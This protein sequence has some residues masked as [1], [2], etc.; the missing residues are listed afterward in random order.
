MRKFQR[1][2]RIGDR[3]YIK[4]NGKR[5]MRCVEEVNLEREKVKGDNGQWYDISEVPHF[6]KKETSST[7]K[8]KYLG[9]QGV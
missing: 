1:K 2:P 8:P 9:G 4:L 6:F 3:F 7:Q 5:I